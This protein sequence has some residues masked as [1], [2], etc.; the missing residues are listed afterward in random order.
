MLNPTFIDFP[1]PRDTKLQENQA[2]IYNT[3]PTFKLNSVY[4]TPT[5]GIGST[6]IL[7]LRDQR[8]GSN[9]ENADV[10]YFT[11]EATF[12]YTIYDLTS[13]L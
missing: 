1:K 8:Q 7:S 10:E 13:S 6:Y 12:K 4:R 2:I 3:G 5:V 9:Q 11:A